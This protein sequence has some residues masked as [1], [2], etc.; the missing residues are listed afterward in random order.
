MRAE[1]T[2]NKCNPTDSRTRQRCCRNSSL[3]HHASSIASHTWA[4]QFVTWEGA[5]REGE[6][7]KTGRRVVVGH[8]FC[9][10]KGNDA[11]AKAHGGCTAA[12]EGWEEAD[13][14][15]PTQ[16]GGRPLGRGVSRDTE[17][18]LELQR[19]VEIGVIM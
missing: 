3:A 8:W 19:K 17:I 16:T 14:S 12:E 4:A 10:V 5:R 11:S 1:G 7:N 15:E 6:G 18:A 13:K 9:Q 2:T